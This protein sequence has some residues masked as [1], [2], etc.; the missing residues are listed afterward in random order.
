MS[1]QDA[2]IATSALDDWNTSQP[3]AAK[4]QRHKRGLK[5]TCWLDIQC[6]DF[7]T[8]LR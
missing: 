4:Y 1:K 8:G 5:R 6:L 3:N 7:L 2:Q